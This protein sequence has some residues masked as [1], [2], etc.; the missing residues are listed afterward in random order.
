VQDLWQAE[1]GVGLMRAPSRNVCEGAEDRVVMS[2]RSRS[3]RSGGS[4]RAAAAGVAGSRGG[5]RFGRQP[6]LGGRL[7]WRLDCAE[8]AW[9]RGRNK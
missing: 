7:V 4:S 3:S 6:I 8:A 1:P 5:R 2:S 9:R